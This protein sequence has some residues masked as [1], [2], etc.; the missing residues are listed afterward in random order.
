MTMTHQLLPT[1][2]DGPQGK[3]TEGCRSAVTA[4]V[5][6]SQVLDDA[7]TAPSSSPSSHPFSMVKY[8]QYYAHALFMFISFL[9]RIRENRELS[10]KK[11]GPK[12]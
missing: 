8:I 3:T 9:N 6:C 1:A 11:M 7:T 2:N 4:L 10:F 5:F 12:K